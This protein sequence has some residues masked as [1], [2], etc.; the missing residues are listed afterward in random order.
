MA[1][2]L[3]I[4][5]HDGLRVLDATAIFERWK[6]LRTRPSVHGLQ[7]AEP[8]RAIH[9]LVHAA[10]IPAAI[11][12]YYAENVYQG[13]LFPRRMDAYV[14]RSDADE[15]RRHLVEEHDAKIGG[16]NLRLLWG[17]DWL[18]EETVGIGSGAATTDYAP[19]PQVVLDLMTEGGSCR[20]AADMLIAKAYPHAR[21]RL[22]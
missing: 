8:R 6:G 3:G 9:D 12:T 7:V 19:F 4:E 20:E 15:A 21:A 11:T 17:D 2:L 13:H 18:L 5:P 1:H 22:R 10:G 16:A 14:R